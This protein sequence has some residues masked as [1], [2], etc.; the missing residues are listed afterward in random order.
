[1]WAVPVEKATLRERRLGRMEMPGT[2]AGADSLFYR[3][4]I[5]VGIIV[6]VAA[7]V[8]LSSLAPRTFD[9]MWLPVI[10]APTTLW[11][12]G[13]LV[14]WWVQFLFLGYTDPKRLGDEAEEV[15]EI[16]ALR[17]WSTLSEAMTVH[18]GDVDELEE[19][20]R[21]ARRPVLEW[22]GWSTVLVL[23]VLTGPWLTALGILT[24]QT[25]KYFAAGVVGLAIFIMVRTPFLLGASI[26]A[27]EYA[28]LRPLGLA[29]VE[30][31]TIDLKRIPRTAIDGPWGLVSG[32][33]TVLS[34]TRHDRQVQVVVDGKRNRT[35]VEAPVP[36]F[37][38]QSR[39][40]KL[41]AGRGA[42]EA[43]KDN[44]KELRKAKRWLGMELQAGP[45][46]IV[47]E[48][49]AGRRQNMWLYDLWLAERLL[50]AMEED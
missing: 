20:E 48:R 21:A 35:M 12:I 33:A 15:P 2:G 44:L 36:P 28:Y 22:F 16:K 13:I 7:T 17:N 47:I 37:S 9:G 40:G 27:G 24:P 5:I 45:E 23:Y 26:G 18:G 38:V 34:G 49:D 3:A 43:V 11:V 6:V 50:E 8:G 29:V 25:Q 42:P 30:S 1:L 4:Y 10:C 14:Y 39:E 46:G 32:S 19:L 31:P 41:V